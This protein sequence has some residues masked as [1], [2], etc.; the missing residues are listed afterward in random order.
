MAM[1]RKE[2]LVHVI[3]ENES[4]RQKTLT[5]TNCTVQ[6]HSETNNMGGRCIGTK[7]T[8]PPQIF[9]VIIITASIRM[10]SA[11]NRTCI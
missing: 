9:Q 5:Y 10:Y 7:N 4:G 8:C 1:E 3:E 11:G 6:V 2:R